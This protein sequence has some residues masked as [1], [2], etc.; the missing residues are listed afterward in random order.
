[1]IRTYVKED[2]D[3]TANI[4]GRISRSATE[5]STDVD[6]DEMKSILC[7]LGMKPEF[8]EELTDEQLQRYAQSKKITGTVSIC[9]LD[10]P[11]I[12]DGG[13]GGGDYNEMYYDY[14]R[15]AYLELLLIVYEY[16]GGVYGYSVD[17]TWLKVPSQKH[18][19][20]IGA[21]SQRITVYPATIIG[22]YKVTGGLSVKKNIPAELLIGGQWGGA[23]ASFDL[24]NFSGGLQVHLEFEAI[25]DN[26]SDASTRNAIATYYHMEENLAISDELSIDTNGEVIYTVLL[27]KRLAMTHIKR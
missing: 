5:A 25:V 1:M 6:T 9:G 27:M 7:D 21:A 24:P 22:W 16:S 11:S 8:V 4:F 19:D 20:S 23:G 14:D 18:T 12:D 17:A 26:L 10:Q 3:I 13:G 15:D 2:E